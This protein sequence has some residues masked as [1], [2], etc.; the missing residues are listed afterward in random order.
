MKVKENKLVITFTD[1]G[2][3]IPSNIQDKIMLPFFTTHEMDEGESS[4]GL[5][6][7]I[8]KGIVEEHGGSFEYNPL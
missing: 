8:C 4:I 1:S 6:L 2:P 3:G 7:S 5:G